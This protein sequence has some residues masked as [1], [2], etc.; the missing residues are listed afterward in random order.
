[1]TVVAGRSRIAT[2]YGIVAAS[3]PLASR[4]GAQILERGGTAADAAIAAN[5]VLGVVEP[6]MNGIG[7]DLFA[8]VYEAKSDRVYGL[9]ASGW[10]PTGL[11]PA[12]LQSRGMMSMPATGVY[13]V[14]VPG[15][16]SGWDALQSRF[17][18]L[19]LAD[20]LAPAV[21][22]AEEGFPV[23]DIIAERWAACADKLGADASASATFLVNGHAPRAG[24]LFA[25]RSLA[26]SLGAIAADGV[27]AF[28]D[29]PIGHAIVDTLRARGGTMTAADLA[30]FRAEWV[31]PVSTT[32]RGWDV[33]ELPPNTQGIA[34]LLMLGIMEQFPLRDFGIHSAR[35]LHVM[36]EA[37]KL[38]YADMLRYAADPR[39]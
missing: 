12:L 3:Q 10:S 21:F 28:Y 4:A 16:V 25:N 30:E 32:Y 31:E 18:S 26:R 35:A 23:S 5:A 38:A 39:F 9:N 7:G 34:A 24:E 2:R 15:C 6:E 13:T 27:S 33:F 19:R 14:T 17:G 37:K 8:I 11:T 20:V 1:M 36:I 22:Y 29:G